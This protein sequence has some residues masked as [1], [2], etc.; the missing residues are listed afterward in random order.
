MSAGLSNPENLTKTDAVLGILVHSK[1]LNSQMCDI[2]GAGNNMEDLG[3]P[4]AR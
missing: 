3:D 2:F 4:R 1:W